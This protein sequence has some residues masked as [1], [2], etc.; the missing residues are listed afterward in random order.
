MRLVTTRQAS[1]LT[2]LSTNK[3]REWTSRRALIPADVPPK[4]QGS[5]ARY[6]WQTILLLRIA[7]TLRD[8]FHLEL[9]AHRQVLTSLHRS[10]RATSFV[11]LWGK[12]LAIDPDQCWSWIDDADG[13]Q[14]VGDAILVRLS[15]HLDALSQDFA[16]PQP[17]SIPGQLDLFP[18]RPVAGSPAPVSAPPAPHQAHEATKRRRSA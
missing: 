5:P 3:L 18:A 4:S 11:S 13:G 2:G 7:V 1:R 14:V 9:Q 8:R 17:S 15:P 10:L 12:P 6:S 16:L